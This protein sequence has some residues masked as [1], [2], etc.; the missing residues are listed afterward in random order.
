MGI[1]S[2]LLK[3]IYVLQLAFQRAAIFY[4]EFAKSQN[5]KTHIIARF[6]YK[7]SNSSFL[8]NRYKYKN[9]KMVLTYSFSG[10]NLQL[11]AKKRNIHILS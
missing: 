9:G 6:V 3:S 8:L 4:N 11:G 10:C 2:R 1:G 7:P 5:F